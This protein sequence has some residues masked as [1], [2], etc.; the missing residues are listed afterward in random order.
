MSI[1]VNING[2]ILSQENAKISVFDRGFLF[3]DSIYDVTYSQSNSFVF[4][5]EHLDRL[6]NSARLIGME[7][8]LP[9]EVLVQRILD[10]AKAS[11]LDE[12]YARIIVTRGESDLNISTDQYQQNV[13]IYIK[14]NIKYDPALYTRGLHLSLVS[15]A[16]NDRRSLDPNAKSGNYLNNILAL[17]EARNS[18]AD[19]A[20][21][22]NTNGEVAEGTTFNIW[23][24]KDGKVLTPHHDSGLLRGVTRAKVIDICGSNDVVLEERT[25]TTQELIDAD[26]VFITSATKG[27]MPVYKLDSKIYAENSDQ[28]PIT[29]A[30]RKSYIELIQEHINKGTYSY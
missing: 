15:R 16:R 19:D 21:M 3:G 11:G 20:V 13:V 29:E 18:G 10:T 26:E 17:Q 27:I 9:R 4:L 1:T 8:Q 28:R 14:P 22:T 30:L 7:I 25:I 5:D 24:V 6:W 23:M 2:E 12:V